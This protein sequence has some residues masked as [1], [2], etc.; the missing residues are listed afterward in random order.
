MLITRSGAQLIHIIITFKLMGLA[1]N[2]S[3]SKAMSLM[4]R[5]GQHGQALCH[6]E[7]DV[8]GFFVQNWVTAHEGL[9]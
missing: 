7:R 5:A 9:L 1:M 4:E 8:S 3:I 6:V 2:K